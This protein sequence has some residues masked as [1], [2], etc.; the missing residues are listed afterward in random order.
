VRENKHLR[1]D[2]SLYV[3]ARKNTIPGSRLLDAG[4]RNIRDDDISITYNNENVS[5]VL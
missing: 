3:R 1:K 4:S 2:P 5:Y